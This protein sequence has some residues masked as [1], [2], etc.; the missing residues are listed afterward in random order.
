MRTRIFAMG[1]LCTATVW[2]QHSWQDACFNHPG[3][4]YCQGRDFAVKQKP[5]SNNNAGPKTVVSNVFAPRH[6]S[7]AAT[8]LDLG[9]IDW[10]FADPF[11]DALIGFNVSS[12]SASPLARRLVAQ[13]G[14]GQGLTDADMQK[15]FSGLSSVDQAALSLR[16]NRAVL[17][18]TGPITDLPL[19]A[20]E[21]GLKAVP[22]AGSAL[23]I[24]HAEAVDQAMQ[25]ITRGFPAAEITRSAAELQNGSEFWAIG[26]PALLGPQAMSMGLRRF[27]LRV[28][29]RD[30]LYCDLA[31]E[32]NGAPNREVL[33]KL[34]ATQGGA[35]ATIEGNV[36]HLRTSI[37][38]DQIERQ[39]AG[40]A[41]GPAGAQLALLVKAARYLPVPNTAGQKSRPVIYGL[42]DGPVVVGQDQSQP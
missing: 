20:Q 40:F 11:P 38:G 33:A 5:S 35:E 8:M 36:I 24:G 30:A 18:V 28:S 23:L 41:S 29:V 10:R 19:P 27:S 37:A 14:A 15:I 12:I 16:G 22:T 9:A 25:R 21:P 4:P 17:M 32:F 7:A 13:L 2:A 6:R 3:L 26:S 34:Q 39:F 42:D 31:L 1:L